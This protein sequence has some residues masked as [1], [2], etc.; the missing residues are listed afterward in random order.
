MTPKNNIANT[1]QEG[2]Q[3]L[4]PLYGRQEANVLSR[5]IVQHVLKYTPTQLLVE[6]D[7]PLNSSE[8]EQINTCWQLLLD[9]T[10]LQ[11]IT[12]NTIFCGLPIICSPAALIPRPETEE[13]VYQTLEYCRQ[14]YTPGTPLAILDIGTGTGCIALALKKNLPNAHIWAIDVS[15]DALQLARLNA[16]QLGLAL[17][18]IH[19]DILKLV[20]DLP[21][22]SLPLL[23]KFDIIISNPP[24][25]AEKEK[26]TLSP[27]VLGREPDIALFVPDHAPLLF[28]KAILCF[29]QTYLRQNGCFFWEIN[30]SYADEIYQLLAGANAQN[31]KISN[32]INGKPRMANATLN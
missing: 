28:Y 5:L 29:G 15:T 9:N 25:I 1:L 24:Y 11:Y 20:A 8:I 10:P 31:I 14:N 16:Q 4:T 30:E 3:L 19:A 18:L 26:V 21:H 13:L 6:A 32:D 12:Q 17:N 23:P 7:R 2:R 22:K 27:N